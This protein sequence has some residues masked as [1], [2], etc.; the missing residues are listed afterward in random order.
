M[1]YVYLA[2]RIK[3]FPFVGIPLF[4]TAEKWAHRTIYDRILARCDA[5]VTNTEF[6]AAF[7]RGRGAARTEVA[8]VG[9]DPRAF[10]HM[11]GAAIRAQYGLGDRPV[12]GFVGRQTPNK[13]IVVILDAIRRVWQW[14]PEVRLVLAGPKPHPTSPVEG[15]LAAFTPEERTRIVCIHNFAEREKASIYD[16][17]D[18]LVLPSI[19]ESFGLAYLEAWAC[20]KPVIGAR[21][22]PTQCVIDEGV[23]GYLVGPEDADALTCRIKELLEDPAKRERMGRIGHDKTMARFTWDRVTDKVE[24]L[25]RDLAATR[26]HASGAAP[27][28]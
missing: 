16:A 11:D 22:G 20:S 5:V 26:H 12:V 18:L 2:R 15:L 27:R 9:I 7:A 1:Y 19:G 28:S 21:I 4:H 8:G 23:D 25:Y 13:G 3:R 14:N 10:T 6:E 24:R 17:F